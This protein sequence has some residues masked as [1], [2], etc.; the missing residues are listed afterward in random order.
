MLVVCIG[1]HKRP[2]QIKEYFKAA[3]EYEC[4]PTQ[5]VQREEGTYNPENGHFACTECYIEMGQPNSPIGW[6][7]P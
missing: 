7:A 5:F 1:C 2:E 4:T 6:K 3:Q